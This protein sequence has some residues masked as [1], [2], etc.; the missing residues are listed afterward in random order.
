L[1]DINAIL[2]IDIQI[3][4]KTDVSCNSMS[5]LLETLNAKM[6]SDSQMFKVVL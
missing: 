1:L 3:G 6:E 4:F 2:L 5:A